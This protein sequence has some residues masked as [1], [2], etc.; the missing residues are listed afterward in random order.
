MLREAG[1]MLVN[2]EPCVLQLCF[3][4]ADGA[5]LDGAQARAAAFFEAA[6]NEIVSRANY[7][8]GQSNRHCVLLC[9]M[10]K[11]KLS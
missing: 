10:T 1:Y 11:E 6:A 4:R 8:A 9:S 5:G 7:D 2:I 3:G